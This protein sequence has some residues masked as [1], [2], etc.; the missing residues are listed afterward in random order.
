MNQLDVKLLIHPKEKIYR[1]IILVISG[2][3]WFGLLLSLIKTLSKIDALVGPALFSITIIIGFVLLVFWL[4]GLYFKALIYGDSV[5][6]GPNQFSMIHQIVK[7]HSERLGLVQVPDVFI[8]SG[9]GVLNA[10][11]MS[12]LSRRYVVLNAPII[13]L[14]MKR[15]KITELAFVIGHELVH[16]AA[17]H[18]NIWRGIFVRPALFIPF[19]A[20]AFS[21]A[22]ELTADRIGMILISDASSAKKSL[23]SLALG[24]ESLANDIDVDV[25]IEQEL[26]IPG[27]MG[28]INNIFSSHPRMTRRVIELRIFSRESLYSQFESNQHIPENSSKNSFAGANVIFQKDNS[29]QSNSKGIIVVAAILVIIVTGWFLISSD[30]SESSTNNETTLLKAVDGLGNIENETAPR[31]TEVYPVNE[32]LAEAPVSEDMGLS[33]CIGNQ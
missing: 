33:P 10:I 7:N 30:K 15:G 2:F 1:S 19:F 22:C 9:N 20:L 21:R 3:F 8:H 32:G 11:A 18:T 27:L 16:H 17:G 14:M 31:D 5:K 23:I 6:V 25:F 4:V 12:F 24:S 26:E 28:F 29:E 13:D